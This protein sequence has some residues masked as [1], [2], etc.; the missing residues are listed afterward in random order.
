MGLQVGAVVLRSQGDAHHAFRCGGNGVGVHHAE[1]ALDGCHDLRAAQA[2]DLA[3]HSFY[4][5]LH[6]HDFLGRL[7]LGHA[8]DVDSGF[9][10]GFHVFLA[11]GR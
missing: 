3:L 11:V 5:A 9:H 6:L 10:H 4:L 2:T 7:G 1:G 8:Y